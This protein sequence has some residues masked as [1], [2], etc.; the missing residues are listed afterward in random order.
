MNDLTVIYYTSNNEDPIFTKNMQKTL[1]E[2]IGDLSLISVSQKP[3]DFGKNICV[4]KVGISSHNAWRQLQ[5]GAM[6]AKTKFVCIAEADCLYPKEYFEFRPNDDVAHI[7]KPLWMLVVQRGKARRFYL[8]P[9]GS[10]AAMIVG[11]ERLVK[12]IDE[13]FEGYDYWGMEKANGETIPYL[14]HKIKYV[15]DYIDKPIITIKTDNNMHRR[16]P[17][18]PESKCTELPYWGNAHELADKYFRNK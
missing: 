13:V 15:V 4:G 18:L 2:T 1:L 10:E 8:K 12:A 16:T 9:R 14:L 5:I 17:H 11:R 7:I 3:I 6:S